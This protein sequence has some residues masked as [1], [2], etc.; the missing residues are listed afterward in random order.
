MNLLSESIS[1]YDGNLKY[2]RFFLTLFLMLWSPVCAS[3][4]IEQTASGSK[5]LSCFFQHLVS[6]L[7]SL[8]SVIAVQRIAS[9]MWRNTRWRIVLNL[10]HNLIYRPHPL[11][12]AFWIQLI[13]LNSL[14]HQWGSFSISKA[15][16]SSCHL[17]SDDVFKIYNLP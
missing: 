12:K 17:S 8:L 11:F 6:L 5:T 16:K 3:T 10:I 9:H 2:F 4:E 7:Y 1:Y 13:P 15:W 14:W